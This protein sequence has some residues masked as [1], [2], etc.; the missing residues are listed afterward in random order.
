[1]D[2]TKQT[3]KLIFNVHYPNEAKASSSLSY[4]PRDPKVKYGF[5]GNPKTYSFDQFRRLFPREIARG[6]KYSC[7]IKNEVTGESDEFEIDIF[8]DWPKNIGP[9]NP[10]FMIPIDILLNSK[11]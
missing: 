3:T 6:T 1:M 8:S 10:A 7:F 2:N 5:K 11:R 9:T 4:G